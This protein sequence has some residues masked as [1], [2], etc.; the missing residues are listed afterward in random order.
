[1]TSTGDLFTLESIS[2]HLEGKLEIL[3]HSLGR[4]E[5][6]RELE[7]EAEAVADR[8]R[9]NPVVLNRDDARFEVSET[10]AGLSISVTIAFTGDMSLLYVRP[11][12]HPPYKRGP[13]ATVDRG[14]WGGSTQPA[15]TLSREFTTSTSVDDARAWAKEQVDQIEAVLAAQQPQIEVHNRDVRDRVLDMVKARVA[16]LRSA[17]E[18]RR[19][20]GRGI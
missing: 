13:F 18:L 15:I 1:M 20:L 11:D 10:Q 2:E 4:R 19:G 8:A 17:E 6:A 3:E 16:V 9:A 7:A 14:G 5:D 12:D